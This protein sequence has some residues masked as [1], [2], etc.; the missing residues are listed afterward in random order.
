[1]DLLD[2]VLTIEGTPDND[3]VSISRSNGMVIADLNGCQETY[4]VG[5]VNEVVVL[6]EDGDEEITVN[7][8]LDKTIRGGAGNDTITVDGPGLGADI[9]GDDGDD[10]LVGGPSSDNPCDSCPTR[11]RSEPVLKAALLPE[12]FLTSKG[13]TSRC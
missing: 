2:G 9:F 3:V 8:D 7:F 5:D 6:G 13:A 11:L 12:K 10:T 4:P 1:M